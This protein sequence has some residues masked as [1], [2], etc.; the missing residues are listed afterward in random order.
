MLM[1]TDERRTCPAHEG[2]SD[3]FMNMEAEILL[4]EGEVPLAVNAVGVEG[5]AGGRGDGIGP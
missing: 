1:E 3:M 4:L 2:G 5:K